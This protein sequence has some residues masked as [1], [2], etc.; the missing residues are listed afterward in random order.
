LQW[1][2]DGDTELV[3]ENAANSA[4]VVCSDLMSNDDY[5]TWW[6]CHGFRSGLRH[7]KPNQFTSSS[8]AKQRVHPASAFLL[9]RH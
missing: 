5:H 4:H 6:F 8:M 3:Q 1:R 7:S 2:F 9:F